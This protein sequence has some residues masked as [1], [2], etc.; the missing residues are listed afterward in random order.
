[1]IALGEVLINICVDGEGAR[2]VDELAGAVLD[3]ECE[4]DAAAIFG[5][6]T[7][8]LTFDDTA[9]FGDGAASSVD[10]PPVN[11]RS[12]SILIILAS[13]ACS[14]SMFKGVVGKGAPFGIPLNLG[15][16]ALS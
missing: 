6:V 10:E 12:F 4:D 5:F 9:N 2:V 1:M 15:A 14:I 16:I 7:I 3:P 8:K 13:F 11:S